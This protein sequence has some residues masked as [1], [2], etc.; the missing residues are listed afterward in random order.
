MSRKKQA[1]EEAQRNLF[2]N[3]SWQVAERND[4]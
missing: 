1:Q 3:L 2:N 4:E